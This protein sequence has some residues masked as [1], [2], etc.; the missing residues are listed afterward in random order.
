MVICNL[1]NFN[2]D[3]AVVNAYDY[4]LGNTCAQ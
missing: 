3:T 2:D 1:A 4:L